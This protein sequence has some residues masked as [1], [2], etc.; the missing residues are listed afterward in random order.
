[1]SNKLDDLKMVEKEL[2][3]LRTLM[4]STLTT[5]EKTNVRDIN[6][7]IEELSKEEVST[8]EDIKV[9]LYDINELW[10]K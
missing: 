2:L 10:N 1:M 9:L 7:N 3:K 5:I 8:I 6:R 4:K